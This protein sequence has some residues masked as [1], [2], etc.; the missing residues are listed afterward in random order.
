[1]DKLQHKKSRKKIGIKFI[2]CYLSLFERSLSEVSER[3]LIDAESGS[4]SRLGF[5]SWIRIVYTGSHPIIKKCSKLFSLKKNK[6]SCF[7]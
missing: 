3:I 2:N 4:F 6:I 1:M 5:G 7:V